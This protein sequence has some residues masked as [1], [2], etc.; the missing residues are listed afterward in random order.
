MKITEK[1]LKYNNYKK[2]WLPD[3]SSYYF[4]KRFCKTM[5]GKIM[6]VADPEEAFNSMYCERVHET[7]GH[8]LIEGKCTKET[9]DKIL[10]FLN[11]MSE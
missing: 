4:I 1:Y 5:I 2:V 8:P 6:I 7:I 9:E 3:K 10:K 11:A